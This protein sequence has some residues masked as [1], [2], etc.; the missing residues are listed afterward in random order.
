MGRLTYITVTKQIQKKRCMTVYIDTEPGP[1]YAGLVQ[2]MRLAQRESHAP[3]A[4]RRE[5]LVQMAAVRPDVP[6]VV[7]LAIDLGG[8]ACVRWSRT[9]AASSGAPVLYLHGG[10]YQ[11]GSPHT[12]R[13]LPQTLAKG[14]HC[15]VYSLDYRLAPEHPLPAALDDALAAWRPLTEEPQ[16]VHA[17]LLGDSAGGGLAL[18]LAVAIRD[19]A[20][21]APRALALL[22]PWVDLR[23]VL[24]SHWRL[25][26]ADPL[27]TRAALRDAA[28]A[29][30]GEWPAD[31]SRAS[32]LLGQLSGLPPVLI[33]VGEHE[34]L[35]D[36]SLALKAALQSA[37][38]SVKLEVW[39]QMVHAWQHFAPQL[40][41]ASRA[42]AVVQSFLTD[43]Q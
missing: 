42:V 12:H 20:L 33:Q 30:L 21:P 26:A 2:R 19:Q 17:S 28:L 24:G 41:E 37:G 23:C 27:M 38:V 40:P 34:I 36:D 35:L 9:G 3:L 8:V 18:A 4:L 10:A 43:P 14:L 5:R 22:S 1:E 32:P 39:R 31:D 29:Y 11:L 7:G 6:D 16:A 15:D 25:A 13:A